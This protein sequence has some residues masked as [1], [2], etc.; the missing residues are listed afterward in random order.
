MFLVAAPFPLASAMA[1]FRQATEILEEGKEILGM[2]ELN[3]HH[4]YFLA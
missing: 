1:S 2:I 4:P 3:H